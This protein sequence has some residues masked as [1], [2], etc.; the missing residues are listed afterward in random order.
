MYGKEK[1][2]VFRPSRVVATRDQSWPDIMMA[3]R[4]VGKGRLEGS[5]ASLQPSLE[6]SVSLF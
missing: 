6:L 2:T 1:R 4:K 3:G 5:A